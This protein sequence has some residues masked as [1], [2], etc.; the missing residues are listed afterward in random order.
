MSCSIFLSQLYHIFVSS[1][2]WISLCEVTVN[3]SVMLFSSCCW[4]GLM[5][6]WL[7]SGFCKL[8]SFQK[9]HHHQWEEQHYRCKDWWCLEPSSH[10]RQHGSQSP[11]AISSNIKHNCHNSEHKLL[12]AATSKDLL[13]PQS[14]Q[15]LNPALLH[16]NQPPTCLVLLWL[17]SPNLLIIPLVVFLA[18]AA[19]KSLLHK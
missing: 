17:L 8:C 9:C 12:A 6:D 3:N 14:Q 19:S 4:L 5:I 11:L 13:L 7:R 1:L 10:N 2:L 16:N 15:L 18:S